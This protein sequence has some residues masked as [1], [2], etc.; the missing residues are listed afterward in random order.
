MS[1]SLALAEILIKEKRRFKRYITPKTPPL[2]RLER[3]RIA[4]LSSP[5]QHFKRALFSR[6]WPKSISPERATELLE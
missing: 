3:P 1:N 2:V 6:Q 4:E 5:R